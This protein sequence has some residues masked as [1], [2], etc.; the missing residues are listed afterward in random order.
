MYTLQN[1]CVVYEEKGLHQNSGTKT[2][3][4]YRLLKYTLH[5]GSFVYEQQYGYHY[6]LQLGI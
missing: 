5:P 4:T 1:S 2:I 3:V 6:L